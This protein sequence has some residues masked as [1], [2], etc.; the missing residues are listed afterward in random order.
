MRRIAVLL[1]LSVLYISIVSSLE[2]DV[3]ELHTAVEKNPEDTGNRLILSRYYIEHNRSDKALSLLEEVLEVDA[4]NTTA[5]EMYKRAKLDNMVQKLLDGSE[6]I[7][8]LISRLY[9]EEKYNELIFV[10]IYLKEKRLIAKIDISDSSLLNI[11]RVAMWNGKYELSLEVLDGLESKVSLEAYEIK[12][13]DCFWLGDNRCALDIYKRL[14]KSTRECRYAVKILKL[15]LRDGRLYDARKFSEKLKKE[16]IACKESGSIA[17]KIEDRLKKS[18]E[19]LEESYRNRPTYKNLEALVF[20]LYAQ[21]PKKALEILERHC[22]KYPR[23]GKAIM[24]KARILAWQG[25]YDESIKTIESLGKAD[26]KG[27]ELLEAKI[28]AWRGDYKK[29]LNILKKLENGSE[30]KK[31]YEALKLK[32]N[33]FLWSGNKDV[34]RDI[35]ER[36]SKEREDDEEVKESLLL[37]EGK[38]KPLIEKYEKK[39]KEEP[40]NSEIRKRL[41]ELYSMSGEKKRALE[42]YENMIE[43]NPNDVESYKRAGELYL[44]LAQFYKGF[45]DWEYYGN[46]LSS[47]ESLYELAQRY[48]WYGYEDAAVSVL[49]DLLKLYPDERKAMILKAKALKSRP[50]YLKYKKKKGKGK[51]KSAKADRRLLE[52]ADRAY[53]GELFETAADYY[54]SYIQKE[55]EDYSARERYAMALE[56]S[57]RY[58]EAAGEFYL[59]Q[60]MVDDENIVYHYAYNLQKSNK[61][62][63]ARKVYRKLLKRLP[64]EPPAYIK[65][66]VERW[67]STQEKLD[68]EGYVSLYDGNESQK[69]D[70][71]LRT[72]NLFRKS[73][74]ISIGIYDLILLKEEK[75]RYGV[76]FYET[77][78]SKIEKR[79]GYT[80][81]S[82]KCMKDSCLIEAE[83]FEESKY[84]PMQNEISIRRETLQRL[85]ELERPPSRTVSPP[86]KRR[87]K[88][89]DVGSPYRKYHR[90][91][92]RSITGKYEAPSVD[93]RRRYLLEL[94]G[95]YFHD[96]A[97]VSMYD[98][99]FSLSAR[100][101]DELWLSVS[102]GGYTV[103]DDDGRYRGAFYAIG[104]KYGG[105]SAEIIQNYLDGDGETGWAL[106][107]AGT[108]FGDSLTLSLDRKNLVYSKRTSCAA[109]LMRTRA[110][111]SGYHYIAEHKGLWWSAA[112]EDIEDGN[113][114]WTLQYDYEFYDIRKWNSDFVLALSGWYQFNSLSTDCYYSP[115]RVDNTLLSI[116][117]DRALTKEW[118]IKGR[119]SLGYSFEDQT[120]LY[121][122]GIWLK[123]G[124]GAEFDSEIGC[125]VGS[126]TGINGGEGYKSLNCGIHFRRYL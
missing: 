57:G 56:K 89:A 43:E 32:A 88:K 28:Y 91:R 98:G 52:M 103:D 100:V 1:I 72:E 59:M 81:L 7:D 126:G 115:Q 14:Y 86:K 110:E 46:F 109:K 22:I 21:E 60:W 50:R 90:E 107:Y 76:R 37:L 42:Y 16:G 113:R 11:A 96:N 40:D 27:V 123:S 5:K 44:E 35:F 13:E 49:D 84:T 114:V 97:G 78:A 74:F 45:G 19:E 105:I 94:D 26:I 12:A 17:K 30:P 41:A 3:K 111:I 79:D 87:R 68:A 122:G 8:R 101:K 55:P 69:S 36:L 119:A 29:A 124:A 4:N 121:N 85:E 116:R 2:I 38:I 77:Y 54:W 64:K 51:A 95:E 23:D 10:Y 63:R 102:G 112:F 125:E 93:G 65:S 92:K 62:E 61:R 73:D 108:L 20:A 48:I 24:L 39:L 6:D 117:F 67:K 104:L 120:T 118:N 66:L 106:E 71:L 82:I 83:N 34:A 9:R 53:E 18:I 58:E 70:M 15:Y 25:R 99:A 47:R 33:I 80:D 31:R 75:E